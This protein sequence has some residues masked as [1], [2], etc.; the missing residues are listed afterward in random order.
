MS[1]V[2]PNAMVVRAFR[3]L[4]LPEERLPEDL[5]DVI[6][7]GLQKLYGFQHA[8]GGWG[9]WYDDDANLYQ[10]A[11]VLYGL[12]MTGQAGY[13]VDAGVLARGVAATQALLA[14]ATDPRTRAYA[15]FV[16]S[17]AG[18]GDLAAAQA[19]LGQKAQLD[20]FAQAALALALFYEGDPVGAGELMDDLSLAAV[21]TSTT[22]HWPQSDVDGTYNRK[23]MAS[24]TRA[25][26]LVLEAF[27]QVRPASPLPPKAALWL[28]N[29][30]SGG[31]WQTT[32]ETAYA[33][34]ALADYVQVSGELAP[35]YRYEVTLN[36][37][38]LGAGVVSATNALQPIPAIVAP[39]HLLADGDNHV[40]LVK[41]GTGRLY[42]VLTLR[43]V[44]LHDGFAAVRPL[45]SGI[46]VTREYRRAGDGGG[47]A[48]TWQVGDL[49]SVNLVVEASDD[50]WYVIINDPLPAGCEALN[51]RLNTNSH[52]ANGGAGDLH[53]RSYGYNR[54]D[55]Y[56]E[57][58]TLFVTQLT[59]G[60]YEYDYLMR[61]TTPGEFSVLPAEVYLMY[62]PDTWARSASQRLRIGA[63][64]VTLPLRFKGDFDRDCR[65]TAFDLKQVLV[66]WNTRAGES[67]YDPARDIV[68]NGALVIDV[69][70]VVRVASDWGRVC[71]FPPSP[72]TTLEAH[73]PPAWVAPGGLNVVA[74]NAYTVTVMLDAT[75]LLSLNGYQFDLNFDPALVRVDALAVRP[76]YEVLGPHVDAGAGQLTAG[77]FRYGEGEV[78]D[79]DGSLGL[80]TITFT[81]LGD[82]YAGFVLG[83]VQVAQIGPPHEFYLPVILVQASWN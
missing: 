83:A 40:H 27:T 33:I 45:G 2:L 51:E 43:T 26:A 62:E 63:N 29:Q 74:G 68:R 66:P 5:D 69:L 14:S 25:T 80:A 19:L 1:R 77:A 55:V 35:D 59:A 21:E 72:L 20:Y 8:D 32:Q 47:T 52:P 34:L 6:N 53:W 73:Q 31:H 11:Y 28:M 71:S 22:A 37:E 48:Q 23:A 76:G 39:S 50:A 54:K 57:R 70:D 4:G 44:H 75:D 67:G 79:G 64:Q 18:E 82:G 46:S 36:G 16:L 3:N 56:D 30:R 38:L 9:W 60:R 42:Y 81:A 61:A 58:V 7:Q 49:I 65:V 41:Q 24:T 78:L 10:T 12:V 15:L 13:E 17:T